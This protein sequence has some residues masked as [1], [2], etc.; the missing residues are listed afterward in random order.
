MK[1]AD[2]FPASYKFLL[3]QVIMAAFEWDSPIRNGSWAWH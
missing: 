3:A 1:V 2:G